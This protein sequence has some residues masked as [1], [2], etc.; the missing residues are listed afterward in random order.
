MH[1]D[2]EIQ[3]SKSGGRG[4]S[5]GEGQPVLHSEFQT[6]Q[7]LHGE[8]QT[9]QSYR[10]LITTTKTRAE[11][12]AAAISRAGSGCI[13]TGMCEGWQQGYKG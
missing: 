1:V 13:W 3:T 10:N 11:V 4:L 6:R 9:R 8:F 7:G 12:E 2:S 5:Q